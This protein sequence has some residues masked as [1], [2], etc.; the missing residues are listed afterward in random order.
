MKI[1]HSRLSYRQIKSLTEFFIAET[2]ARKAAELVGVNK[3]T[4]VDFF[5]KLRQIIEYNLQKTDFIFDE[6]VEMDESYFGGRRK[7]KR[8]RGAA[9]KVPVFGLLK[10]QGKVYAQSVGNTKTRTLKPIILEKIQADSVVYSDKY[11]SYNFLSSAGFTHERVNHKKQF[12]DNKNK[13]N[14]IN[15]VENFWNQAK[16]SMRKFN[17]VPKNNFNLFLKECEF[18]FNNPEPKEQLRLI[19]KFARIYYKE[20][21]DIHRS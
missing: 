15:G 3:K 20:M 9:G 10:R 17:G 11:K 12:V 13:K 14:H 21:A 6:H 4:A 5:K 7:G 1:K 8:G 18:R 2:T 19:K 16:R